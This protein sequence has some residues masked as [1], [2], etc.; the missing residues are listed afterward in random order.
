MRERE[1]T[2]HKIDKMSKED[3]ETYQEECHAELEDDT[4]RPRERMFSDGH[5]FG[6]PAR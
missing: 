4:K 2:L 5:G 6:Q 3:M 1:L